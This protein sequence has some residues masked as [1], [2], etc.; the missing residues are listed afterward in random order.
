MQVVR[1]RDATVEQDRNKVAR[2]ILQVIRELGNSWAIITYGVTQE[3]A[4]FI[5]YFL[6]ATPT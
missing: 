6:D 5:S 4:V 1:T 3:D 2:E